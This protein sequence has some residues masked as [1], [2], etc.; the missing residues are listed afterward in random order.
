MTE[1]ISIPAA[2]LIELD[3]ITTS[4]AEAS[5]MQADVLTRAELIEVSVDITVAAT[6][7]ALPTATIL[8]STTQSVLQGFDQIPSLSNRL[9]IEEAERD[10]QRE[11]ESM[12]SPSASFDHFTINQMRERDTTEP[13]NVISEKVDTYCTCR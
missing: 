12:P 9:V 13:S 5:V 3:G 2:E 11:A 6:P 7:S 8:T 4:T 10:R 1:V